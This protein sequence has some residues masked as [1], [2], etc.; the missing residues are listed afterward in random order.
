MKIANIAQVVY[1]NRPASV[2]WYIDIKMSIILRIP[3]I[4]H[5]GHYSN[6]NLT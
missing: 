1:L 6:D 2:Y 4:S 3:I 5:L